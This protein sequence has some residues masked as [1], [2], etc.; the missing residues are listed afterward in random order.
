LTIAA[1]EGERRHISLEAFQAIV[2]WLLFAAS[3]YVQI[4]PAPVDLI[5]VFAVIVF[6]PYGL[7]LTPL[8]APLIC[9]L[10]LYNLGCVLSYLQVISNEDAR[11]FAV[12]SAYM[13][14]TAIFFAFYVA[15][16]PS[17]RMPIIRNGLALG[18]VIATLFGI[19]GALDF[20]GLGK[21]MSLYG[22]AMGTFK[23]PNVFSTYLILPALMLLQSLI[24]GGQR[25]SWLSLIGLLII[26][27]GLFLA[28]SRGAWVSFAGATLMLMILTFILFP[29]GG[30][31]TRLVVQSV[32]G[33]V[34]LAALLMALLAI[35][36]FNDLFVDRLT[37]IKNYDAGETGRFGRQLHSVPL[38]LERPLGFGPMEFRHLFGGDPH[39]TF[40]NAFASYGWLGGISYFALVVTTIGAGLKAAFTRAPWQAWSIVVLCPLLTTILQG[41]QIDTDHWRHF[42]WM[43]GMMWGLFAA[44]IMWEREQR[45][46]QTQG[47]SLYMAHKSERSAA[48]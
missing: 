26:L 35:P 43:L 5:F 20:A 15:K 16:A 34:L 4:E 24:I 1:D 48:R 9:L 23:D 28:F 47:N 39:N 33:V 12:T 36:Q 38:L 46:L 18:A 42:Y 41:I 19:A 30:V 40:L 31:R 14:V 11:M 32:A 7:S 17:E 13:A 22:R 27:A 8:V 10:L 3:F 29:Q 37:L 6:L 2:I 21:L 45:S 25:R 44:S